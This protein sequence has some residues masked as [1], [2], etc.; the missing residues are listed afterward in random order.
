[1]ARFAF[2]SNSARA[3]RTSCSCWVSRRVWTGID[4]G[5]AGLFPKGVTLRTY[6]HITALGQA[7][8]MLYWCIS[9]TSGSQG[10]ALQEAS[11]AH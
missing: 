11:L 10:P 3:G 8:G 5:Q 7:V 6:C 4:L 1:M 9:V 2:A